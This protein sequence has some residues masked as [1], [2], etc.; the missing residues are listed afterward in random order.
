M[1]LPDETLDELYEHAPCGYL[2]TTVS[3]TIVRVN[4]TFLEWL[5]RTREEAVGCRLQ[6]L[7]T[8]GARIFYETHCALQLRRNGTIRQISM[9]LSCA[10]GGKFPA[11]IDWRPLRNAEREVIGLRVLV[12]DAHDRRSYE[13][14]L[15]AE[16]ERAK[17]AANALRE[18]NETLE[19]R[20]EERTRELHDTM[21]FARLALGAVG[22]VGVWT[23][24]VATDRFVCDANIA[25]LYALEP[26]RG[27]A[28]Y[29]AAEF[30]RNLHPDDVA[31][32]NARMSQGLVESGDLE[33]EYR[34]CHPDGTVHWVLSR[35]PHL[36]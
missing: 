34:I 15:I 21:D 28:G 23:Y 1:D 27:A 31:A 36:L 19:H 17:A 9:D 32:L 7:L 2:T 26:G 30:L 22:G 3:G 4:T 13:R 6:T 5:G 35:G 20:V 29:S 11:L 25:A 33:L 24:D 18:L 8:E 12:V 16:R 10:D 14:E